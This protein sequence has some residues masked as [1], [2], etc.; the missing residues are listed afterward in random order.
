VTAGCPLRQL[1]AARFPVLYGWVLQQHGAALGPV[2]DDVGVLRWV[3]LYAT[4]DYV[5]RWLW[6]RAPRGEYPV[7]Q[8]DETVAHG[9]AYTPP[10]IDTTNWK[11][12]MGT[13]T[14]KDISVGA[15][16]HTHYFNIDQK[17]MAGVID[18]LMAP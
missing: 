13:D 1:Y 9:N 11:T 16:A 17:T 12:L 7:S 18:A 8:I 14:E 15:G 5:G 6:S 10:Y 3:N 2:A 4:G